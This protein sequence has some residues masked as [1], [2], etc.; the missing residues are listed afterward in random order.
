MFLFENKDGG[1]VD[2]EK[3]VIGA[4]PHN[5][6]GTLFDRDDKDD[7]YFKVNIIFKYFDSNDKYFDESEHLLRH[8]RFLELVEAARAKEVKD[9]RIKKANDLKAA[10]DAELV[11]R[12]AEKAA[13]E[14][15]RKEIVKEVLN[16]LEKEYNLINF[17]LAKKE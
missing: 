17:N 12:D 4:N 9:L 7:F 16:V 11:A 3:H 2:F 8:S 15:D 14:K 10:R 5:K 13:H 1:L 6:N